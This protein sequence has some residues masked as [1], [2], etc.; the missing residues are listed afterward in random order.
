MNASRSNTFAVG[1][2]VLTLLSVSAQAQTARSGGGASAQLLQQMQQLASERTGLQAEN[3]KLKKDLEDM[4]KERD[5]LKAAQQAVDRRAQLSASS[6]KESLAQRQSSDQELAQTKDKMQQLIA[7]F[8]ETLQTLRAVETDGTAAKQTLATRDQ[9]LKRCVDRNL[10]LYELNQEVLTRL[11]SQSVWT[12]VAQTEPFT[13]IKRNQLENL[14]DEYK[15]RADDQKL[16]PTPAGPAPAA[17]T[18]PA[19]ASPPGTAPARTT[20]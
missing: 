18:S 11:E 14:V 19:A 16:A 17:A 1:L 7:K 13:R 3:A 20:P 15:A 6:L 9:D 10:A 5:A 2:G 12:R 8:R 4:R